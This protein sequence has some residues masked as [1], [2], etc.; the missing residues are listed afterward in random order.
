MENLKVTVEN[1]VKELVVRTGDAEKL[2][3][4]PG[5]KLS[6]LSIGAVR[7]FLSKPLRDNEDTNLAIE[8]TSFIVFDYAERNVALDYN[9]R[10]SHADKIIGQL[11]LD[12]DLVD[13]GINDKKSYSALEMGQFIR[14]RRHYFE[15]KDVALALEKELKA[16]KATVDK[17]IEASDD[18]R[19]NIQVSVAQNVISNLPLDFYIKLPVFIGTEKVL[20]KVEIDINPI[21]LM[22]TLVSPELKEMIDLKSKEIIDDEIEKIKVIHPNLRIFQ[23]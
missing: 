13:F 23:K 22:C 15:S 8:F 7:E 9:Y 12:P 10:A 2:H 14:F 6:G 1:D 19:G 11:Q 3:V 20:I 16:F 17:K 18:K 5:V 4:I 21:D